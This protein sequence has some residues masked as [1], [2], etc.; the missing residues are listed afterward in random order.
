MKGTET[1]R[2]ADWRSGTHLGF[3][4]LFPK[5]FSFE[6]MRLWPEYGAREAVRHRGSLRLLR[7]SGMAGLEVWDASNATNIS[8]QL[9][10][11]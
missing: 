2:V 11:R 10:A 9:V 7:D 3:S 8:L 4:H 1:T 5:D 6:E